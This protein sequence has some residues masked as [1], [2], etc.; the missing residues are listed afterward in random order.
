[1]HSHRQTRRPI[2]QIIKWVKKG[3][4][5]NLCRCLVYLSFI[6]GGRR[7][8]SGLTPQFSFPWPNFFFLI[9]RTNS[10]YS[11]L[12]NTIYFVTIFTHNK[13]RSTFYNLNH[14]HKNSCRKYPYSEVAVIRIRFAWK[15]RTNTVSVEIFEEIL[16]N[17][18]IIPM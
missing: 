3:P 18:L 8:R 13:L 15:M 16:K 5:E 11:K 17:C 6:W 14:T 7:G 12:T 4:S 9:L 2:Q 1:M 10:V